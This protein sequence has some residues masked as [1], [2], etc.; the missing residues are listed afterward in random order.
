MLLAGVLL[1][2]RRG[3]LELPEWLK[4]SGPH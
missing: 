2:W 3:A 4:R 1:L